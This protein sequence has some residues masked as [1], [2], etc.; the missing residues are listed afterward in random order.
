MQHA[1]PF[2][3]FRL[4]QGVPPLPA[5]AEL[6]TVKELAARLRV[7]PSTIWRWAKDGKIQPVRIA[8][9]T[10]WPVSIIDDALAGRLA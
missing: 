5:D 8:G 1:T 10:R 6:L 4:P 7:A 9:S 2:T 3:L